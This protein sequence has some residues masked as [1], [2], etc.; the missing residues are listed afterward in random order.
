M[1]TLRGCFELTDWE[2]FFQSSEGD[3]DMINDSICS[4]MSFCACNVIQNKEVKLYPN[5]P[6]VSKE[7]KHCIDQ[8]KIA[9]MEGDKC[10]FN[11]LKKELRDKTR[12]AKLHYKDKMEERF[13]GGNTK[14]AW[15]NL[16]GNMMMGK[17]K[18]ST[19]VHSPVPA[20]FVEQLN[21]FYA[22]FDLT[23]PGNEPILSYTN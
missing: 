20:S 7:M 14:A 2:M 6:W 11:E 21:T 4:Y 17:T 23:N 5:K 13:T 22:R 10:H 16:D 19:R 18:V 3:L 1:E 15:H 8:K 9:F 12:L